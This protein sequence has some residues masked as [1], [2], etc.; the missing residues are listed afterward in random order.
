MRVKGAAK[1]GKTRANKTRCLL[2]LHME[3]KTNANANDPF[4]NQLKAVSPDNLEL[5]FSSG[6]ENAQLMFRQI[7]AK[8]GLKW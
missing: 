3:S 1:R 2:V 8:P 4:R 6:T 7:P 5:H